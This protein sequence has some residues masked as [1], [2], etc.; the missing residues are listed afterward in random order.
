M[1]PKQKIKT[2]KR[3][4]LPRV[5]KGMGIELLQNGRRHHFPGH[6]RSKL[7][8]QD[9]ICLDEQQLYLR[10][11]SYE[12]GWVRLGNNMDNPLGKG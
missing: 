10:F 4:T 1:I 7:F 12:K 8:E 5:I 2:P 6:D 11:V 3:A 9:G